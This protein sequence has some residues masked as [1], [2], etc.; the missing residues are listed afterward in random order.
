M[1]M[2]SSKVSRKRPWRVPRA[3]SPAGVDLARDPHRRVDELY[4]V[5]GGDAAAKQERLPD[6]SGQR[7]ARLR[8]H[9]L[10]H[11]VV[12]RREA[13][14]GDDLAL[15]RLVGP[16]G[17]VVLRHEGAREPGLELVAPARVAKRVAGVHDGHAD[18]PPEKR[19]TGVVGRGGPERE[20]RVGRD[21]AERVALVV[22]Q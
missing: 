8:L 7:P 22:R 11:V 2:S 5:R 3:R 13:L 21:L 17:T 16:D 10:D 20:L 9:G 18:A 14:G 15:F 1:R 4:T 12:D 6:A 19:R